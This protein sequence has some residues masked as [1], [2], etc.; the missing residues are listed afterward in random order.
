MSVKTILLI[1]DSQIDN[2]IHKTVL[3]KAAIATS[4]ISKSSGQDALDLLHILKENPEEFP[5]V[6]FLDI[7]M[8]VMNGFEFLKEYTKLPQYVKEK[9]D[10]F[11]LSSSIDPEDTKRAKACPEVTEHLTKPLS[12]E[13]VVSIFEEFNYA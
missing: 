12:N 11:I 4:I 7:T 5:E 1:D 2:F 8:P 13:L 9:C 10:V 6:I 3:T